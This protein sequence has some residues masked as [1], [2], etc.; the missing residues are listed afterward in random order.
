MLRILFIAVSILAVQVAFPQGEP[1]EWRIVHIAGLKSSEV[2]EFFYELKQ[3]TTRRDAVSI[4]SMISYPLRASSGGIRNE[5]TCRER[6]DELF[7]R[8]VVD[9]ITSQKYE[10]L[11]VRDQGVMIGS[12]EVWISGICKDDECRDHSLKMVAINNTP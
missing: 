12:G 5:A 7:N 11:F 2:K 10:D 3:K 9:A 6:F 8:R 1:V 4:C